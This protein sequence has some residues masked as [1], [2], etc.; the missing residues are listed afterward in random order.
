MT[1]VLSEVLTGH[2][3]P[4]HSETLDVAAGSRPRRPRHYRQLCAQVA[5]ITFGRE[6]CLATG[7]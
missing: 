1:T 2:Y 6:R 5:V 3:R 7:R 4:A